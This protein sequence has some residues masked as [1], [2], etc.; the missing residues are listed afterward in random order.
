MVGKVVLPCSAN[1]TY[2][3]PDSSIT[4]GTKYTLNDEFYL[5]SA[6][7]IFNTNL[8]VAD[9]SK[10]FPLYEGADNA[11]RIKYRDGSAAHWWL[12]TPHSGYATTVRIVSSDGTVYINSAYRAYGLAP[13]CTIV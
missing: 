11:D 7:E 10:V 12:R 4:K 2:E 9:D 1:N 3:A 13:A 8:D 5:A 6:M